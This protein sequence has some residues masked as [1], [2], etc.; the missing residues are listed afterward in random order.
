LGHVDYKRSRKRIHAFA[1]AAPSDAAPHPA[2][3]EVDRAEFLPFDEARQAIH[4][5]QAP[6]LDRLL[7]LL[8]PSEK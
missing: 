5:D 6:L 7:E 4:P 3:W 8:E 2:S 1:A